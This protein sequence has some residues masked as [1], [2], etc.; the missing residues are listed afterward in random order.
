VSALSGKISQG[1]GLPEGVKEG[2]CRVCEEEN[3][4][5]MFCP[6]CKAWICGVCRRK[7]FKRG[8][9]ALRKLISIGVS[10]GSSS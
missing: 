4:L 6:A 1:L 2:K 5:V 9:A 10:N 8:L 3:A 7:Y